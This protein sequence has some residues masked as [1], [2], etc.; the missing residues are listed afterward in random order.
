MRA[1]VTGDDSVFITEV[2]KLLV[3]V[4]WS[5][6]NVA[7]EETTHILTAGRRNYVDEEMLDTLAAALRGDVAPPPPDTHVCYHPIVTSR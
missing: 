5:D 7:A 3:Q 2:L 4:A 1:R 6:G